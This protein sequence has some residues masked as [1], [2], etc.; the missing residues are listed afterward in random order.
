MESL[1]LAQTAT[2]IGVRETRRIIGEYVVTEHDAIAGKRFPDVVAISSNPMPDF[3]GARY[4]FRH[5]DFDIPYRSLVP[6]KVEGLLL[7]G[8]CISCEQA[9]SSQRVL[10]RRQWPSGTRPAARPPWLPPKECRRANL[11]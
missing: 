9:P 1:Y 10:W 5:A 2:G 7:S 4:F 8:R 3:Y 6:K 11:T